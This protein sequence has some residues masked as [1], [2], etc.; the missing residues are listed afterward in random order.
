M[1]YDFETPMRGPDGDQLMVE[2]GKPLTAYG[3]TKSLLTGSIKDDNP[4]PQ[5]KFDRGMLLQ[6]ISMNKLD[7][8]LA[9]D[10]AALLKQLCG[11]A[12]PPQFVFPFWNFIE[13]K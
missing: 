7:A 9:T 3:M 13:G 1:K 5:Q 12:Y 8:E 4:T 6:R 2:D 11:L 10:E